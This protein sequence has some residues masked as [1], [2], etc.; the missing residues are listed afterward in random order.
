MTSYNGG[1][2]LANGKLNIKNCNK[3]PKPGF[4]HIIHPQTHVPHLQSTNQPGNLL[5]QTML[6]SRDIRV[7]KCRKGGSILKF[8]NYTCSKNSDGKIK[9]TSN[10]KLLNGMDAWFGAPGGSRQPPR[11]SF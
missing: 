4:G 8:G 5:T 9:I 3:C 11:N 1:Y 2:Y 6:L 10:I 7:A